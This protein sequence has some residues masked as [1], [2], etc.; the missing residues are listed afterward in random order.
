ML[1]AACFWFEIEP[2]VSGAACACV[3]FFCSACAFSMRSR[4]SVILVA[5][6]L[7][8]AVVVFTVVFSAA[9][10][11]LSD[12]VKTR[13]SR[14]KK[15]GSLGTAGRKKSRATARGRVSERN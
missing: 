12:L 13:P 10:L 4:V 9:T 14:R 5:C 8:V 15:S 1:A 3:S 6:W 11:S 7:A 2:V